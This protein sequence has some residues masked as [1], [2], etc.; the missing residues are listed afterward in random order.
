MTVKVIEP[1][2]KCLESFR[3]PQ[4]FTLYLNANKDRL[5]DMT[6][7]ALNKSYHIDGYRITRRR[8][9]ICL[10]AAHEKPDGERSIV[11]RLSAAEDTINRVLQQID[12]LTN[13]VNQL[14]TGSK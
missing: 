14:I 4:D 10:I 5:N 7:Q 6:T 13:A 8:G 1:I 3:S 12:V 11:E 2:R 9:E